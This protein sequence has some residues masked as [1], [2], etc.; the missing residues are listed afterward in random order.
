[1]TRMCYVSK[2]PPVYAVISSGEDNCEKN[3]GARTLISVWREVNET[4]AVV[5]IELVV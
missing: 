5:S 3:K 1:M 2:G 4:G